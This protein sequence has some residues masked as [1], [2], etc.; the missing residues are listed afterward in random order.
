MAVDVLRFIFVVIIFID[1]HV[2]VLLSSLSKCFFN[3]R[4]FHLFELLVLDFSLAAVPGALG[5]ASLVHLVNDANLL[6]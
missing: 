6:F 5:A 4:P 2:R 1:G 3:A